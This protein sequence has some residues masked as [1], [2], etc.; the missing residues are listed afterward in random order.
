MLMAAGHTTIQLANRQS[1]LVAATANRLCPLPQQQGQRL[2]ANYQNAT[3]TNANGP[4]LITPTRIRIIHYIL[5]INPYCCCV[6]NIACHIRSF[7]SS[8]S[9][10]ESVSS[11]C[12]FLLRT[13]V[14]FWGGLRLIAII[15][16]LNVYYYNGICNA[17]YSILPE[18]LQ[19]KCANVSGCGASGCAPTGN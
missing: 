4:V 14:I 17:L 10:A 8:F 16:I 2:P 9:E 7:S 6:V 12:R 18:H 1:R 19:L 13:L 15:I 3:Y 5:C 11:G